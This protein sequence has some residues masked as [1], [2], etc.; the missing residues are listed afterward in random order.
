MLVANPIPTADEI[1]KKEIDIYISEAL[2]ECSK[3]KI[4]GK[5][6][7]PF[8]LKKIVELT[9]KKSLFSNVALALNNV[10]LATKITKSL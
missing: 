3:R 4:S 10:K 1:P 8:L 5:A 9:G 6:V 2:D 7:T